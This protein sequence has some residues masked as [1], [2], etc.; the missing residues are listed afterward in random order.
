M[1]ISIIM[2]GKNDSYLENFLQRLTFSI[3]KHISNIKTLGLENEVQ[4]V[5]TDWCS[6]IKLIDV[7]DVD[8]NFIKYI[9][10]KPEIT[11]K[12]NGDAKYSY[13]HPLNVSAR[14]SDGEFIIW[15]D[16]DGFLPLESF[17]N[18]YNLIIE[19]KKNNQYDTFYWGS[20]YHIQRSDYK[21]F[22]TINEIDDYLVLNNIFSHDKFNCYDFHGG[23]AISLLT[24]DMYI[25]TTGMWEKLIYWGW[26]DIEFHRRL[27]KK[28]KFGGDLEDLNIKTYHL[29]HWVNTNYNNRLDSTIRINE[30]IE[31]SDF[32]A[33]GEDWGLSNEKLEIIYKNNLE[34]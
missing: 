33:N 22:K 23:A 8:F 11:A 27:L 30:P 28:Y 7:L 21:D 24:K 13:V 19:M 14:N 2:Q 15:G 18:L 3:S 17:K 34:K 10:V 26:Q 9:Y 12:Y 6:E 25:E 20:R 16:S 1:K 29:E 31:S 5:L 4:I 32:G